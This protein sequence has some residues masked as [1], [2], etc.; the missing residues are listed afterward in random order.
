M[1]LIYLNVLS[2]KSNTFSIGRP[3]LEFTSLCLRGR[4]RDFECIKQLFN[5]GVLNCHA[6]GNEKVGRRRG[7]T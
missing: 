2:N 7:H 5:E 3:L 4:R 1:Y 6:T